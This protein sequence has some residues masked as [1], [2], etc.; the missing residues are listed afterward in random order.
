MEMEVWWFVK[1]RLVKYKNYTTDNNRE[2]SSGHR[3]NID[4]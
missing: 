2:Y 3:T 4:N 1:G